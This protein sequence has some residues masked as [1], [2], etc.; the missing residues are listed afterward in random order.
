M[1]KKSYKN[2]MKNQKG[3]GHITTTISIAIIILLVLGITYYAINRLKEEQVQNYET[4]M[5]LIQGKVK[6]LSQ[7]STIQKNEELLKGKKVS[8]NLEDEEI[9]RLLENNVISQDA[10]D[11]SKYYIIEKENLEEMGLSEV[12]PSEGHYIVN[13]KTYEIIYSN[14]VKADESIFYKLSELQEHNKEKET[15][16]EQAI[17][18]QSEQGKTEEAEKENATEA[19]EENAEKNSENQGE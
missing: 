5:L 3:M 8:E 9:A 1:I 19:V 13:Y 7:E 10:E 2:I 18:N 11:F 16:A 17:E 6:I 15:Q 4:D 12:E 14:G